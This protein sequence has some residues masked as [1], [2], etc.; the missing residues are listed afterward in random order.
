MSAFV[1]DLTSQLPTEQV[2]QT[3]MQMLRDGL[4]GVDVQAISEKDFNQDG[5]IIMNPPS[6][7][8]FFDGEGASGTSD[9][10]RLSYNAVGRYVVSCADQ[11]LRSTQ[12]QAIA[13]AALAT[14][15]KNVAIG[16]R[17]QL[18]NGDVTE[19][20]AWVSTAVMPVAGLGIGYA[21][22]FEV[23]GIAQF[24]GTNAEG[25]GMNAMEQEGTANGQ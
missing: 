12:A 5:D 18:P 23:P 15:V 10:Q 9:S 20:I 19:P 3:L 2:W 21:L 22:G 8:V 6:V 17:L 11:N 25:Y 7:R 13:S 1:L 4:F 14:R 24:P 16:A